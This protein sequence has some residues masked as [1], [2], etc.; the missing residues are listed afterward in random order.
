[1]ALRLVD[2]W[3]WD[4]WYVWDGDICHAFYLCASKGL[5]DPNRRHR[6][7][8]VGHATSRDLKNWEIHPD[9]LAPSDSPAFDSWTTWTGSVVRDESGLWWMF[10]TG[11][12]REDGGQIQRIGAATSEDLMSWEKVSGSALLEADPT[13]YEL[14]TP[15][16]WHDQ[17]WRDPWVYRGSDQEWHMLITARSNSG[18]P[19]TRG[20]MG[21]A[22]SSDLKSWEVLQ[23]LSIVGSDFGQLEVFQYAEV[24]GVPLIVFSCGWREVS[25]ARQEAQGLIDYTYSLPVTQL[26]DGIDFTNARP[27]VSAPVYAGRLVEHPTEGWFLLGFWNEIEGQ[28]A[29]FISNP[30]PVSADPHQGLISRN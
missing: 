15:E 4:S 7:T 13:W 5:V 2:R 25:L 20:V 1:M 3:I 30:I 24:D 14:Y 12:S 6:Y 11:T 22:K 17:A 9:V 27:F 8:S 29:G 23:P 10:Y 21:H 19:K 28:F 26:S 18:N 16:I